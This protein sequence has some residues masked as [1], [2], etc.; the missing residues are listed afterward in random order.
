MHL[1]ELEILANIV[2]PLV[3]LLVGGG[4]IAVVW[5]G[6]TQMIKSNEDR[7]AGAKEAS[8][9][10]NQ[11]HQEAMAN[12]KQAMDQANQRHQEA[13]ANHK[14]VMDQANQRHQEAMANHK[15][16][17]ERME[18]Q[19]NEAMAK[20]EATMEQLR[21]Q[22]AALKTLIERNSQHESFRT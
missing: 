15:E 19:H 11:R 9:Q 18:K 2:M 3:T 17:M 10:A 4:Q 8:R 6:I 5:W 20:H 12:H 1:S 16:V 13:M 22:G 7:A 21:Q 14:Q